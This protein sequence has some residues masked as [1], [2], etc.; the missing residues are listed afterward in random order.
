[1]PHTVGVIIGPWGR[2]CNHRR[3]ADG[4]FHCAGSAPIK[5]VLGYR[6]RTVTLTL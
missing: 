2:M 4:D 5:Y 3:L 1:M 6:S